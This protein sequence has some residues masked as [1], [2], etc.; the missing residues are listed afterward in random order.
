MCLN[1]ID[2]N[3]KN[4]QWDFRRLYKLKVRMKWIKKTL[5][6]QMR[7]LKK[8]LKAAKKLKSL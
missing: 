6:N 5:L 1:S 8:K 3:C 7:G 4:S 2:A